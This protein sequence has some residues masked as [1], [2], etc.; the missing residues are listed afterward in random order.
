MYVSIHTYIPFVTMSCWGIYITLITLI[1]IL[2]TLIRY[3]MLM[4]MRTF[5]LF[6]VLLLNKMI[7]I[8]Q[9]MI[10]LQTTPTNLI[11]LIIIINP[12]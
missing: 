7:R 9:N 6:A 5:N 11:T 1:T 3:L 12:M 10:K 4:V 2:I 8:I